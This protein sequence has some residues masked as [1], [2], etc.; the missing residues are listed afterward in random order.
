MGALYNGRD[1]EKTENFLRRISK[2]LTKPK[3]IEVR[4]RL[5]EFPFRDWE[6]ILLCDMTPKDVREAKTLIPSLRK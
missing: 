1:V 5:E 6:K 2:F 3:V 4:Q